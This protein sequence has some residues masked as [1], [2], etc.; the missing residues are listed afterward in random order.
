LE[1][2][3]GISFDLKRLMFLN[4][5]EPT[6]V[7]WEYEYDTQKYISNKEVNEARD[8]YRTVYIV[9]FFTYWTPSWLQQCAGG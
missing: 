7:V 3:D 9:S 2:S 5:Y 4:I 8:R 6:E 1:Y